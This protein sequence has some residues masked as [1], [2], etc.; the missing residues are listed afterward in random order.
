MSCAAT[1]CHF[2]I[3]VPP[4]NGLAMF[5]VAGPG[6]HMVVVALDA[7]RSVRFSDDL[8]MTFDHLQS[9]RYSIELVQDGV[10]VGRTQCDAIG[11]QM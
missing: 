2:H 9:A 8:D 10:V 1:S 7:Q 6:D 5:P 3:S 11:V 4:T